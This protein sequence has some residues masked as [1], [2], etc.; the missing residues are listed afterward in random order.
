MANLSTVRQDGDFYNDVPLVREFKKPSGLIVFGPT[1]G[2][3]L[4]GLTAV[5]MIA[6]DILTKL[7]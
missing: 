6:F 1:V 2:F 7:F 5:G 3:A 4:Y